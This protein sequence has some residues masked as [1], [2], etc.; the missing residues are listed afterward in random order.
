M[1]THL[2]TPGQIS[3]RLSAMA[4]KLGHVVTRW[5]VVATFLSLW[6][7]APRAAWVEPAFLP[8]FSVVLRSAWHLLGNGQLAQHVQASLSRSLIVFSLARGAARAVHWLEPTLG[9]DRESV[10][11]DAP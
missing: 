9:R 5:A 1:N 6:E 7:I 8:P 11:G 2:P 10:P 4:R 3:Q